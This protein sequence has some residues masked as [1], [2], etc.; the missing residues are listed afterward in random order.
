MSYSMARYSTARYTV[1]EA[2]EAVWA[3]RIALFFVQLLILTVLLH[4]FA[5]L[6]TPAAINLLVVSLAGLLIAIAIAV[7]SLIRIWFGGQS[8]A[9]HAVAAV[10]IACLGLALPGYYLAKAARLPMLTDVQTSPDEPLEFTTLN[11][12][13]PA[14]AIPLKDPT[15]AQID[16]QDDAYPDLDAMTLER[17]A[18]EVFSIVHEAVD[19]LGWDIVVNE[20]PGET[21]IGHIEATARSLIMGFTN[22]VVIQI[23]GDDAH[24]QIDARSVSRYGMTDFGA[25]AK[26]IRKLFAEVSAALEKGEKTVLEQA[27]PKKDEAEKPKAIKKRSKKA[28]NR[29]R[30]GAQ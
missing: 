30:S 9:S 19:R 16:A 3:R 18:P 27:E 26:Y 17:S 20:P 22:D 7:G 15:P 28:A 2:H 10:F 1:K 25:N 8:G 5:S 13:R 11:T 14:N 21:G 6:S 24:A 12:M 4:R 29:K 23:K